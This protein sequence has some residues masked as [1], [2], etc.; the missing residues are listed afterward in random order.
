MFS[1]KLFAEIEAVADETVADAPLNEETDGVLLKDILVDPFVRR[2]ATLYYIEEDRRIC[3]DADI[4]PEERGPVE[5]H[6]EFMR[7]RRVSVLGDLLDL[8][9]ECLYGMHVS[10]EERQAGV[11]LEVRTGWRVFKVLPDIPVT[12]LEQRLERTGAAR[13]VKGPDSIN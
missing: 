13:V 8:E 6:E 11:V 12:E 2:L 10:D 9:L 5:S 7:Q 1:K 3:E 4:D